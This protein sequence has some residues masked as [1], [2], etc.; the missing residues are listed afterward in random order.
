MCIVV[1]SYA[2]RQITNISCGI[3]VA[4]RLITP[5]RWRR[6]SMNCMRC[7]TNEYNDDELTKTTAIITPTM[8][9][10]NRMALPQTF[11]SEPKSHPVRHTMAARWDETTVVTRKKKSTDSYI[12]WVFVCYYVC[13][14]NCINTFDIGKANKRE[15]LFHNFSPLCRKMSRSSIWMNSTIR[16]ANTLFVLY[17]I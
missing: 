7:E 2:L 3:S 8:S 11:V 15:K 10:E 4:H 9:T 12:T 1:E 6:G 5:L 17:T 14:Y 13:I 16:I